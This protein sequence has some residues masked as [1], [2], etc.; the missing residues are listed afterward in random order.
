MSLSQVGVGTGMKAI[1]NFAT[2]MRQFRQVINGIREPRKASPN[3]QYALKDV[4][5]NIGIA[6]PNNGYIGHI[7]RLGPCR[8]LNAGVS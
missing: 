8:Q 1:L 3:Q 7:Q 2:L 5:L 6:S 4:L